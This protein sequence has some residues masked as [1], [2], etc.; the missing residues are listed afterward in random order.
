MPATRRRGAALEAAILDAGWQQL[1]DEGYPRFTFEAIS[2]RAQTGKAVLYRRWPDKEALL[3]AVLAHAGFSTPVEIPDTGSLRADVIALLQTANR[4]GDSGA[5]IFSTI[6]GAYYDETETTPAQL[7]AQLLGDSTRPM[8]QIVEHAIARGELTD[9]L[10]P[11]ILALPVDLLRHE[12]VM[13]LSP[14]SE[15]TIDDI[16]DTVFLP[17]AHSHKTWQQQ[18]KRTTAASRASRR[19]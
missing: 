9:P 7:R 10:P 14:A 6:L 5:A 15:E 3:L 16:V 18:G 4:R 12:L 11:R 19:N 8:T 2:A 17:L 1:I 13:N